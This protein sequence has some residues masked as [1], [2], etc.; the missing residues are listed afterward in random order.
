MEDKLKGLRLFEFG[1]PAYI[2]SFEER[3][4]QKPYVLFGEDN[5]QPQH[6]IDMFN[7]SS[8]NRACL[9]AVISGII[10]KD[11]LVD[12]KEG[13]MMVNSTETLYDVFKKAATDFAVHGGIAL[14]TI[15]RRDGEG[16]S[17]FYHIDFSKIRSGKVD[18]FDYVK[19]YYYSADWTAPNKYK[20]IEIPAFNMKG[21]GDSQVFYSFP[22]QPNQKY[23]PL[24]SWIGGR[25]PVQIDIEIMN[26]E[27][28]NIQNGY[29][30]S[31]AISLNNGVPSDE[32]REM[33]YR[34][35]EDK[36]SSS[37]NAGKMFLNFSDGKENEPTFT[38]ITPNNNA[39]LFNALNDIVQQ[40]VLTAHGITKPDLLGIKTAGQLGTKQEI[41]EGYEH[42]LRSVIAPKQQYLI[43]E[44][45]KLL[46]YKTGEV[47]KLSIVQNELF[48]G[49]DEIVPGVEGEVGI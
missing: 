26:L 47:H 15:K 2:P 8:V 4:T 43:R 30:P 33:I 35:L 17:D 3:I 16:I 6:S 37:N 41:V 24:P 49:E 39:D 44:F 5:L 34:H 18:D 45:E 27:L 32:E 20:P 1:E 46:F 23:Y 42:F 13:F 11:L 28:N 29:F 21:E 7:F 38:T 14:N 25:I 40:K 31:L 19:E 10:G 9:N 36:Y 48:E 22:Y 12:G